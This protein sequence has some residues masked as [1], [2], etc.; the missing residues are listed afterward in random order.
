[1]IYSKV[2]YNGVEATCD[3]K[4]AISAEAQLKWIVENK[5]CF[6]LDCRK[7]YTKDYGVIFAGSTYNEVCIA[8]ADVHLI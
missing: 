6:C 7:V 8:N 4:N 2:M 5:V 1:M 3:S